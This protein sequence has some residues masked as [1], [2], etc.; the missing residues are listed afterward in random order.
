M[1]RC[2]LVEI[3]GATENRT[4]LPNYIVTCQQLVAIAKYPVIKSYL[5]IA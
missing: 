4:G 2:L 1:S 3:K 5:H